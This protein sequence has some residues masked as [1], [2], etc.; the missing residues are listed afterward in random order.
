MFIALVLEILQK[1]AKVRK[2]NVDGSMASTV[3]KVIK[4][5]K[6]VIDQQRIDDSVNTKKS[7]QDVGDDPLT[8]FFAD[9]ITTTKQLL[10]LVRSDLNTMR[11]TDD[12]KVSITTIYNCH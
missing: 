11:S 10:K 12:L 6:L 8:R 3:S 4:E 7:S 9:E 1:N 5:L 2:D